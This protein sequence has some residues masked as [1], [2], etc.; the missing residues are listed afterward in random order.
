[1]KRILTS[2][3]SLCIVVYTN[4]QMQNVTVTKT[5]VTIDKQNYPALSISFNASDDDVEDVIKNEIKQNDGKVK[6]DD[7]FIIGRHVKVRTVSDS[8]LDILWQIDSRGRKKNEICTVAMAVK[9]ADGAFLS[10]SVNNETYTRAYAYLSELPHKVQLY[11]KDKELTALREQ[12]KKV[13][14]ELKD[15]QNSSS[16]QKKN[17]SKKTKEIEELEEKINSLQK[18]NR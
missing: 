12:L 17:F 16:D 9:Q 8:E 15:L 11:R 4:A 7:G 14:N 3:L 1:M 6:K 18:S 2:M 5:S 13:T 10:D